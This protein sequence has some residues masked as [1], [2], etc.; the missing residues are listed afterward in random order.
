MKK[1]KK[2]KV[3]FSFD[4]KKGDVIYDGFFGIV[5]KSSKNKLKIMYRLSA[6]TIH[7]QKDGCIKKYKF[8]KIAEK[9]AVYNHL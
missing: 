2:Q 9:E 4:L 1:M 6:I 7:L 8:Q 3:R 5:L